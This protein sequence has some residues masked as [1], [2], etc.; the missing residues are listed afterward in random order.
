MSVAYQCNAL[1]NLMRKLFYKYKNQKNKNNSRKTQTLVANLNFREF[2]KLSSVLHHAVRFGA[3][4]TNNSCTKSSICRSTAN[5]GKEGAQGNRPQ[6]MS[7]KAGS[8]QVQI[9]IFS[10][11]NQLYYC[12]FTI[13]VSEIHSLL[14]NTQETLS[15]LPFPHPLHD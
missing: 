11:S 8:V 7:C 12:K 5:V 3:A 1:P 2:K 15:N 6:P 9:V 14:K 4:L 10:I 13:V